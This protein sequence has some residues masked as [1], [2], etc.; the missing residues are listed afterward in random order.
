MTHLGKGQYGAIEVV[1]A[2]DN[3]GK[4]TGVGIQRD[5][6][7]KRAEIRSD[8]FLGQFRGNTASDPIQVGKDIKPIPEERRPPRRWRSL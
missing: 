2:I 6:E 3:N 1:V 4:V 5:R 8:K 7:R